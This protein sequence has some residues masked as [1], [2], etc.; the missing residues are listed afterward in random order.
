MWY[1]TKGKRTTDDD[2]DK[3]IKDN[4]EY[5]KLRKQLDDKFNN[6]EI[7]NEKY[8]NECNK[9]KY[10][11]A[12]IVIHDNKDAEIFNKSLQSYMTRHNVDNVPLQYAYC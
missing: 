1:K 7:S 3:L 11:Q 8:E 2:F 12:R 9:I 6:D 10:L 5:A 4:Q